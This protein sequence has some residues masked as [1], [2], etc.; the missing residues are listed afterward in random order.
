VIKNRQ[1]R[2]LIVRT[3]RIGDVILS[4]PVL[5][6]LRKNFPEAH[7]TMMVNSYTQKIVVMSPDVDEVLLD[8]KEG[9]HQGIRGFFRLRRL[10]RS[11]NF[12]TAV[13]LH[14]T[15]RL[16]LLLFLSGIK[17][18][19]GTG[20]RPY[21]FLLKPRV[22]RHRKETTRNELLHNL[23]LLRFGLGI[24]S[25]SA[26]F[27]LDVK[28][29]DKSQILSRLGKIGLSN[30]SSFIILHPGSAG[31]ARDWSPKNFGLLAHR[32]ENELGMK[33]LI[34]GTERDS[35]QI[36]EMLTLRDKVLPV[37]L[38][39]S[40]N[41]LAALIQR[42]SL[43]ISNSTGPMHL[44]AALGIPVIAIFCPI[45]S[46]NPQRWGPWG[47]GHFVIQPK[48][49]S[50][51]RCDPKRCPYFDCMEMIKVEDVFG[52]VKSILKYRNYPVNL[53]G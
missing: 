40:P 39:L 32:I 5:S 24:D 15:F 16:A 17:I 12:D 1:K 25:F 48:V 41:S 50:C 27:S 7:L 47:K 33:V 49:P 43:F 46:C 10:L 37:F 52:I 22:Y 3:D 45:L 28:E 51:R 26:Q 4:L 9:N 38:D 53:N 44:A 34:T 14:P 29:E 2:F 11:K 19:I 21:S 20:Y 13:L 30:N 35:R 8:E 36:S 31:S 6:T 18:R 42:A 23:D